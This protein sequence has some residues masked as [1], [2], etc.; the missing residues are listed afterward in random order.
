MYRGAN[1]LLQICADV[2]PLD[3]FHTA[4]SSSDRV[5]YIDNMTNEL[6]G[7]KDVE[8]SSRGPMT[9]PEQT[10]KNYEKPQ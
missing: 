7:A 2:C 1:H 8:G 6:R 9:M 4:V 10:D 3:V 5:P